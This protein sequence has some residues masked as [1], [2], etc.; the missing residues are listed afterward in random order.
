[1]S[2]ETVT[3]ELEC[4][5][6]VW[7]RVVQ[8]VQEAMLTGVDCT[9]IMRQVRVIKGPEG[10]LVLTPAYKKMVDDNY[11]KMVKEAEEIQKAQAHNFNIVIPTKDSN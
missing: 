10:T 5:D 2:K 6:E 9:D 4:A 8:I 11:K 1:M 3:E 7:H